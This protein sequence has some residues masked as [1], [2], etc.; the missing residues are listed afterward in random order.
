[1]CGIAGFIQRDSRLSERELR[2]L[3]HPMTETLRRRGPDGS[4]E[5]V[6]PQAGVALGHRRLAIIDLTPAGAQPMVSACGRFV[7]TYNGEVY[8][9]PEMR[10][11]LSSLG[12]RFHGHSDTE[13][14]LAALAEWGIEPALRRMTGMFAF[15]LWDRHSRSLTLARDRVGKKPLYY[16]WCGKTFLFGSELKSLASHPSFA[17]ELD[18]D[19]LGLFIQYSW[20]PAPYCIYKRLHKLLPGTLATI[21][22]KASGTDVQPTPYWSARAT[23]EQAQRSPFTG[24]VDEATHI[25][26][27][28]LTRAVTRRLVADVPLGALLSGG[29]DSSVVVALM[30]AAA[31]RPVKTFTVGF[32]EPAFNEAG[33]ARSVAAHL[34]TDHTE[35]FVTPE[36]GLKVIPDLPSIYDEP[37]ADPSQIPTYLISTLTRQHVTVA[38]SGDGGDELFAGYK[39][40]RSC[41]AYGRI[42]RWIPQPLKE[43]AAAVLRRID[44]A[45][46]ASL[47][48]QDDADSAHRPQEARAFANLARIADRLVAKDP[49][50][51][52]ARHHARCRIPSQFVPA[53]SPLTTLLTDPSRRPSFSGSL[54]G[55]RYLD[56][57]EYLPDGVLV[58]VDRA[59]MAASLEVRCPLLDPEI[60]ELAWRLP[61][62]M[63]MDR[64]GGKRILR[65]LLSRYVPGQLSER[66]KAG[67][68][69]PVRDWLRGPLREWAEDLLDEKR[70]DEQGHFQ[71]QAVRLAWRQ[72]LTGFKNHEGLLWSLLM[73]QAWHRASNRRAFAPSPSPL[74]LG[75]RAR[76][77]G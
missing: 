6:D 58:K 46:W 50:D 56:F 3:V 34:G 77:T 48:A 43:G 28:L 22:P 45:R 31:T 39:R 10:S 61:G 59:S 2:D 14:V 70:L 19:A 53:A 29:V 64:R 12:H 27:G 65:N 8:N 75:E 1:M 51:L 44:S 21:D 13:V 25:L 11:E 49:Y 42:L 74:S 54:L 7:I 71:V 20:I 68:G 17:P 66:P 18:L 60:L 23:L 15:A 9:F 52:L 41:H 69:V 47:G 38:L 72:H 57:A 63:L 16:G 26:H 67:F 37:F 62:T 24:S 33:H 35:L 4:G 5:W 30:Q 76:V 55:M 73:F 36:D 32:R 40:Y